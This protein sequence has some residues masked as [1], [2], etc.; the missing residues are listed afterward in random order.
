MSRHREDADGERAFVQPA[1][2]WFFRLRDSE[3]EA[4]A[5]EELRQWEQFA[6]QPGKRQQLAEVHAVWETIHALG[7]PK[8]PAE[9]DLASDDFD[10]SLSVREWLARREATGGGRRARLRRAGKAWALA[11]ALGVLAL[12]AALY[13]ESRYGHETDAPRQTFATPLAQQRVVALEDGSQVTLG[14]RTEIHVAITGTERA[15]VLDHGEAWF[16]VAPDAR[17]PFKVFAGGGLTTALG[18]E[19]NVRRDLGANVDR[20]TVTVGSGAV[21]VEPAATS[22]GSVLERFSLGGERWPTTKLSK[23]QELSYGSASER[24]EVKRA[25]I[26]AAAAWKEGR[27]EYV[28]Q[29]LKAVVARVNRYS[30]KQIVLA[31]EAVGDIDF[32]GTVFEGQ[33]QEW[34]RALQMAF[35]ISVTETDE[36]ILIRARASP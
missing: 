21:K 27:L 28:H 22:R 17:R 1:V 34:V 19:F 9:E 3:S 8:M 13:V 32:S 36:R 35:P 33:I 29:P 23:G 15:I 24:I 5:A 2:R 4:P 12:S 11:A 18:T 14:A 7:G 6:S 26:E 25:D 31:D 30:D 20:V 16:K 10:G